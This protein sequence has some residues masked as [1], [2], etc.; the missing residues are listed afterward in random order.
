MPCGLWTAAV[1]IVRPRTV[2][3]AVRTRIEGIHTTPAENHSREEYAWTQVGQRQIRG[4]LTEYIADSEDSVYLIQLIAPEGEL[5]LHA[6]Y[7]RVGQ[8]G[9]IQ[10]V[11]E[12][13]H[14]AERQDKPI[15]L[16]E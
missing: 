15:D 6:T 14:A 16:D 10:I 3:S 8:V 13:S 1:T 11:E 4:D 12:I 2:V 9:A 5:F 7:I